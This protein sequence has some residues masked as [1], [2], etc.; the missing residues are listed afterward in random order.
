MTD[1][2]KQALADYPEGCVD[3]RTESLVVEQVFRAPDGYPRRRLDAL[4][5]D[6]DPKWISDSIESLQQ[7]G[8][9]VVKQARI[10]PSQ[11]LRRLAALDII[12]F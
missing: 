9:I 4:L 6:L 1:E 2:S 8:L 12:C 5:D 11:E 7:A 10:Y 3:P